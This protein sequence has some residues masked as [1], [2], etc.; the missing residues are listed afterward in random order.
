MDERNAGQRVQPENSR[1][2]R[3]LVVALLAIVVVIAA[4]AVGKNLGDRPTVDPPSSTEPAAGIT[5]P[6]NDFEADYEAALESGKPVFVY[7]HTATCPSC[8]TYSPIVEKVMAQFEDQIAFVNAMGDENRAAYDLATEYGFEYVPTSLFLKPGG[9][10]DSSFVGPMT[11]NE[12][13]RQL[14]TMVSGQ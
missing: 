12:L 7:F 14:S 10:T 1:G 5:S 2:G 6:G 8:K 4:I 11:E 3:R 9:E 13:R